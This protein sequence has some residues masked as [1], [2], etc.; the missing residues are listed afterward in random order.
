MLLAEVCFEGEKLT[1]APAMPASL[2]AEG[3]MTLQFAAWKTMLGVC[4]ESKRKVSREEK[5]KKNSRW[6]KN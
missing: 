5:K 3:G 6:K 2:G 4:T 1:P